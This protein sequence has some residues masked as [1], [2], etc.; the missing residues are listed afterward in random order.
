MTTRKRTKGVASAVRKTIRSHLRPVHGRKRETSAATNC[1]IIT[2]TVGEFLREEYMKPLG[3]SCRDIA[4]AIPGLHGS[5][6]RSGSSKYWE[7]ELQVLVGESEDDLA[8]W[9]SE[10]PP[11]QLLCALDRYFGLSAGYFL[12][13]WASCETRVVGRRFGT[14]LARVKRCRSRGIRHRKP[15]TPGDFAPRE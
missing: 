11:C 8:G 15:T 12:S 3:L 9:L 6:R 14:W 13:V 4:K 7:R 2:V 1:E 5:S 10:A